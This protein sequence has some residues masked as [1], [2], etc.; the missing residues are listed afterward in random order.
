M[1]PVGFPILNITGTAS[2]TESGKSA[3]AVLETALENVEQVSQLATLIEGSGDKD[4]LLSKLETGGDSFDFEEELESGSLQILQDNAARFGWT[5]ESSGE[6][7]PTFSEKYMTD[8][9]IPEN[10]VDSYPSKAAVINYID[11]AGTVGEVNIVIIQP[12][13]MS[14]NLLL[15]NTKNLLALALVLLALIKLTKLRLVVSYHDSFTFNEDGNLEVPCFYRYGTSWRCAFVL[16]RP[17]LKDDAT[18]DLMKC[19]PESRLF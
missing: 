10:I 5:T 14:T 11:P 18:K 6:I 7:T 19:C 4:A 8:S 16:D 17:V 3:D 13:L 15:N 9:A 1:F 2:S 12:L